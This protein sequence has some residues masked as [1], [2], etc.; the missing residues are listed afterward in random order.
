MTGVIVKE[1]SQN[2][3]LGHKLCSATMVAQATCPN[4]CPWRENGCYAETGPLG[5]HTH[6]LNKV[7]LSADEIIDNEAVGIKSLA[8]D[9]PLRLHVVGDVT[10]DRQANVLADAISD[11]LSP[12]WTYTHSWRMIDSDSFG[13]I[14][15]LASC[16]TE[17]DVKIAQAKGYATALVLDHFESDKAYQ[18][19]GLTILPCPQQTRNKTCASCK[20]CWNTGKLRSAGIT[21]GFATHGSG[22]KKMSKTLVELRQVK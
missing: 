5:I 14:N 19:N 18:S 13:K 17:N 12:T 11:K 8:T 9:L 2:R 6:K 21:I 3:K 20:A 7:T 10:T 1:Y 15:V 16:E 4:T 22:V